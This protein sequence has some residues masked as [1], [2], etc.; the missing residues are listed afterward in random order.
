MYRVALL[1]LLLSA[2]TRVKIQFKFV[3]RERDQELNF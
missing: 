3:M 2:S 1:A